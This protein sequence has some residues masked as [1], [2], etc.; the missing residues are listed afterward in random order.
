MRLKIN[1][2]RSN[3]KRPEDPQK[4][5]EF[6]DHKIISMV[7]N[8]LQQLTKQNLFE[9]PGLSFSKSTT[10]RQQVMKESRNF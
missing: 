2:E 6:K 3:I 10:K 8:P 1:N 7:K 4:E 9:E 5:T